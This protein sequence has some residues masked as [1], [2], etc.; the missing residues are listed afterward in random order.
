MTVVGRFELCWRDVGVV[1][2]YLTV[3]P[4]VVE[5]VDVAEGG[6][7]DV[8]KTSPRPLGIDELPLVEAV[9][10]FGHGIVVAVPART[11]RGDDVVLVE[12][13]GISN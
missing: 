11:D 8:I 4:A 5:P 2:G 12:T 1:L 9:E 6:E 3:Q 10:G 13:L 7:L